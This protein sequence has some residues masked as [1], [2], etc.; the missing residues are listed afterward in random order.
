MINH[1]NTNKPQVILF[2]IG[3]AG[4]NAR[5]FFTALKQNQIR[6]LIDVRLNNVSQLAGFTKKKDLEYFLKEICN[7]EYLHE[8]DFAPTK[9]ILDGYK[10]KEISWSI[11][12]KK[13]L[14]LL[15]QR[16]VSTKIDLDGL[17]MVCLLCSEPRPDHCH[18]R[19]LA[20]YIRDAKSNII[21]KHL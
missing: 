9:D 11:Y 20:E 2:T 14:D 10:K 21:I 7:I 17:N 12:E 4:K 16:Q 19:L 13:Y 18:R 6:K 15:S 8:P 3:F 5:E 1:D